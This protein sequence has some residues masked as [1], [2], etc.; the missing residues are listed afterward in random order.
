[1]FQI[2]IEDPRSF[3]ADTTLIDSDTNVYTADSSYLITPTWVSPVNLGYFRANNYQVIQLASY[4]PDPNTGPTTYDWTTPTVNID[5]SPS[6]HPEYFELDPNTGVLY[7]RLPYYP[8]YSKSYKF[9]VRLI[10]T[11]QVTGEQTFRAR[12]FALTVKGEIDNVLEFITSS[13]LDT[14]FPGIVSELAIVAK[15]TTVP[16]AVNYRLTSG[17]LPVGLSL[18]SDGTIIGRVKY[19]SQTSFDRTRGFNA[20]TLDNGQTTIDKIYKFTVEA[21][22]VYQKNIIDKEFSIVVNELNTTE[23]VQMYIEPLMSSNNRKL[24]LDFITDPQIFETSMLYRP[25]DPEF[26]LQI[27][28]KFVLEHGIKK[29]P[30][31]AYA[32]NMMMGLF[33]EQRLLFNGLKSAVSKDVKG[34]ITYEVV[35]LEVNDESNSIFDGMK[36]YFNDNFSTDEYTVPTWMRTVQ[37][38]YSTLPAGFVKAIPLCYTLPG[39][40]SLIV[41]RIKSANFDFKQLNFTVDRLVVS[42]TTDYSD[43]KYLMFP[44]RAAGGSTFEQIAVLSIPEG[45]PLLTEENLILDLE[46]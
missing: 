41:T 12:T 5:G 44:N 15:H 38:T 24:F 16:T 29:S 26:G 21:T 28:M 35:Y 42:S 18:A 9:T 43:N 13:N 1:L 27:S 45:G 46:F 22:D 3:R 10:K 36:K 14:I 32:A 23:Y 30:I 25:L 7:A 11:D 39:M 17:K 19:N 31:R 2:K 37:S 40:S 4:D 34:N 8:I 6:A 20:F 33:Q